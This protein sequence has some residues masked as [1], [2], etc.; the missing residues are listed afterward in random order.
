[1]IKIHDIVNILLLSLA[2]FNSFS[3]ELSLKSPAFVANAMIP[4]QYT[5]DGLN[6]SPPL[7][8]QDNTHRTKSYVLVVDDPDAP[9]GTWVHWILFNIPENIKRLEENTENP[10]GAISG[11]NSWGEIGYR[12]PCPPAG[13]HHYFFKLYA[14]D[15]R[16]NLDASANLQDISNA[17]QNHIIAKSELIGRYQKNEKLG[18]IVNK[19][20]MR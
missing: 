13:M 2:G 17:M 3:M 19:A 7:L 1:M 9:A 15:T 10:S 5:C 4:V 6:Y 8:W 16:L 18:A 11:K 20:I 12:G 14:L